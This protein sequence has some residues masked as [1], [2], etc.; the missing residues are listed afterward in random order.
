[1]HPGEGEFLIREIDAGPLWMRRTSDA[2]YDCCSHCD[3]IFLRD[4]CTL[5]NCHSRCMSL[6]RPTYRRIGARNCVWRR[7][8]LIPCI[9][10]YFILFP[11]YNNPRQLD[12][13]SGARKHRTNWSLRKGIEQGAMHIA[14][15]LW[16]FRCIISQ[17]VIRGITNGRTMTTVE[18]IIY[19]PLPSRG[20]VWVMTGRDT[21]DLIAGPATV[22]LLIIGEYSGAPSSVVECKF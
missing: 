3:D 16:I 2:Y 5:K 15:T 14:T 1:M 19:G 22:R 4:K 18:F 17:M 6:N 13:L 11:I 10:M 12:T 8:K 7:N 21:E 20:W 9:S